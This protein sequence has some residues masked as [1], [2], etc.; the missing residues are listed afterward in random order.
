M[1]TVQFK[2]NSRKISIA[3]E[4]ILLQAPITVRYIDSVI[5][6]YLV[7]LKSDYAV[8]AWGRF[9]FYYQKHRH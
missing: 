7:Q 9:R 5:S 3:Y 8:L 1:Q 4:M 6:L 2:V